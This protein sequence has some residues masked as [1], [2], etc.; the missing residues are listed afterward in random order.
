MLWKES[1]KVLVSSVLNMYQITWPSQKSMAYIIFFLDL[2]GGGGDLDPGKLS[3]VFLK[4]PH[5]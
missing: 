4:S 5:R 1:A 3:N 2:E